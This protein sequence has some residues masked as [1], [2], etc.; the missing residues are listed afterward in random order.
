VTFPGSVV[1]CDS[2]NASAFIRHSVTLGVY[3]DASPDPFY[4]YND[5]Y[6]ECPEASHQFD[7]STDP[8][9]YYSCSESATFAAG[10]SSANTQ[11]IPSVAITT[12]EYWLSDPRE[13]CFTQIQSGDIPIAPT[14]TTPVTPPIT[15]NTNLPTSLP[16]FAPEAPTF[17]SLSP[18]QA[19]AVF[20]SNQPNNPSVME[21]TTPRETAPAIV[22]PT[23]TDSSSSSVI[24]PAIGGVAAG[25]L[26]IIAVIV[27]LVYRR[28]TGTI[29]RQKSMISNTNEAPPDNSTESNTFNE[30]PQRTPSTRAS[31][32]DLATSSTNATVSAVAVLPPSVPISPVTGTTWTV[33]PIN[34]DLSYKHQVNDIVPPVAAN[35]PF[36]VALGVSASSNESS[37][38]P[39][40]EPPGR[41]DEAA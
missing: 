19:K 27:F 41:K 20:P 21:P 29:E 33:P 8:S 32:Q 23:V 22:E 30:T 35:V 17:L 16:T 7:I 4:I 24:G 1:F 28:K 40:S 3:C 2:N 9:A 13:G 38:R 5:A 36:A 37:K 25:L 12:E 14:T 10:S 26:V 15:A 39:L 6:F 34:R 31:Q 18:N 11:I